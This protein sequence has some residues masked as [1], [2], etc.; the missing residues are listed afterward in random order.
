MRK[1][2]VPKGKAW[3]W[4]IQDEI[5]LLEF[6]REWKGGRPFVLNRIPPARRRN[7]TW[8]EVRDELHAEDPELRRLYERDE[9]VVETIRSAWPDGALDRG[10]ALLL[11]YAVINALED[12]GWL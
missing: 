10:R 2:Y 4:P 8:E 3:K 5:V 11:A 9:L 1:R 7:R 6:E 12:D